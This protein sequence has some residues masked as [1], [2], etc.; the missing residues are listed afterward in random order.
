MGWKSKN[1]APDPVLI[2]KTRWLVTRYGGVRPAA[3]ALNLPRALVQSR[4][5]G[6]DWTPKRRIF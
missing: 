4:L 5:K 3:R 1:N 6:Y 2:A